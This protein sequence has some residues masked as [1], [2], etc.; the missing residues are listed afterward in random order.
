MLSENICSICSKLL[1][2][3]YF[4]TNDVLRDLFYHYE[5]NINEYPS[6]ISERLSKIVLC[7]K[8][9]D[10]LGKKFLDDFEKILIKR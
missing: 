6:N 9:A 10:Q 5:Q 8:C 7:K 2:R 1:E 4:R 3:N